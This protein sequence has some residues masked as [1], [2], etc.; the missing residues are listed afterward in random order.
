MTLLRAESPHG[1]FVSL[2]PLGSSQTSV[3]ATYA[4]GD[5]PPEFAKDT[6]FNAFPAQQVKR[7]PGPTRS[8]PR[9]K[10]CPAP[11]S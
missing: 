11:R 8:R 3:H 6:E 2:P 10:H 9:R 1:V 7:T 5:L 4:E